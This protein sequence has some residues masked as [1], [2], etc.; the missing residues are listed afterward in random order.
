MAGGGSSSVP[1][2]MPSRCG[3]ASACDFIIESMREL[4]RIHELYPTLPLIPMWSMLS[5]NEL[6]RRRIT[7][8]GS[9]R[10]ASD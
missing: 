9:Q 3:D 4:F 6:M 8:D 1:L 10:L 5:Q 7:K 2:A